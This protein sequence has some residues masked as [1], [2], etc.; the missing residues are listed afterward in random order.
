M[1]QEDCKICKGSGI[2][3]TGD[4]VDGEFISWDE[5]CAYCEEKKN[6]TS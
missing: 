3:E 5:P 1:K 4:W 6:E 2:I